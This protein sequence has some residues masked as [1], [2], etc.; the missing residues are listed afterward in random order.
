MTLTN[1]IYQI[2]VVLIIV[3]GLVAGTFLLLRAW[4]N[5]K[6]PKRAM[7]LLLMGLSMLY[8]AGVYVAVWFG[9][10]SATSIP[11]L[12]AGLFTRPVMPLLLGLPTFLVLE[13]HL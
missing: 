12:S 2:F 11:A 3:I 10:T 8:I 6:H 5:M 7:L 13:E 1:L 9:L 4:A